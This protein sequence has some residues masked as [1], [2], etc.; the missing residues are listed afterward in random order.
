[1]KRIFIS[2]ALLI[3][4]AFKTKGQDTIGDVKYSILEPSIF[5]KLN[6][7]WILMDG[8]SSRISDSI[9]KK[10][11]LFLEYKIPLPDAR[12]LFI[13]G[14]NEQRSKDTGD[15]AGDGSVG[16]Y[17]N[18]TFKK[19]THGVT[20]SDLPFRFDASGMGI[21][22]NSGAQTQTAKLKIQIS[23]TGEEETRPRNIALFIYIKVN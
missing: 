3:V 12:G 5:M 16:R 9:Y 2:F 8:G 20:Y 4:I 22:S 18:D 1:M 15:A 19:H 11:I 23:P 10:S 6:P 21:Q 14:M 17:Q 13:R 7:G